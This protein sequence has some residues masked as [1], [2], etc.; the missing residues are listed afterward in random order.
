MALRIGELARRTGVGVSTLRAWE[1]RFQ[2]LDPQR[3]ASGHREY[4]ETDIQ[5]VEAV[6]RLMSEGLTLPAAIARVSSFGTAA[7]PE[8]EGEALL[9]GQIL[10]AVDQGV[11][12]SQEG[13]TRYANR[14]M[15]ELMRCSVETLLTIPILEFVS[16]GDLAVIRERA[17]QL[18]QGGHLHFTHELRRVDGSTFL[19]EIDTTPLIDHTGHYE[20]AVALVSDITDRT[21]AETGS[22]FRAA[23][24]DSIGQAVAA[25]NPDGKVVYVNAAAER[26]FGWRASEV[27]GK[28]GRSLIAA[29]AASEEADEIH[30]KLLAGERFSG[31]LK[32]MRPDGSDFVASLTSS[33]AFDEQGGLLGLTAVITDQTERIRLDRERRTLELQI[34]TLA[35]LGSQA[36]TSQGRDVSMALI[37]NEAMEATRRLLTAD[38]ITVLDVIEGTEDLLVRGSSPPNCE[39]RVVPSGSRS[40]AGYT[41]LVRKVVVAHNARHDQR[42]ESRGVLPDSLPASFV[43]APIF[44]PHGLRGV[45]TAESSVRDKFDGAEGQFL[46]AM[47]SIIAMTLPAHVAPRVRQRSTTRS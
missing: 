12:V 33:P 24:L 36:L 47:A 16:P 43:G 7:L 44:G 13:H 2:F 4:L 10:Q 18:R 14:R 23:L 17:A 9:Y 46:Q 30:A 3:S 22:R 29:P 25:A 38:L 19:A 37:F 6:I 34:E 31:N 26:L 5:R 32:L 21:E 1:S 15:A 40:M 35:A 20:G 41:A 45:V 28:D 11:W 8:G 42:F 39:P 27:I